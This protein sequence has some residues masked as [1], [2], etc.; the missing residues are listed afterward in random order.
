MNVT[1]S[2]NSVRSV[3]VFKL[4]AALCSFSCRIS[5]LEITLWIACS[6]HPFLIRGRNSILNRDSEVDAA[7]RVESI[8]LA[9]LSIDLLLSRIHCC[10]FV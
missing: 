6:R 3:N 4:F 5:N 9:R 7:L 10:M 8:H 1:V 2:L